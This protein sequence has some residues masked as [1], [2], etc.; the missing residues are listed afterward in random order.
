MENN[1]YQCP[2]CKDWRESDIQDEGG[3]K[4]ETCSRCKFRCVVRA[5]VSLKYVATCIDHLYEAVK[6]TG[7]TFHICQRC[8][9]FK[10]RDEE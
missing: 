7:M 2:R 3:T 8:G 10:P 1:D 5:Y 9:E 6:E 4:I